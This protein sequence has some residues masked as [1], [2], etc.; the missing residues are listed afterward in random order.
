MTR[1][2]PRALFALLALLIATPTLLTACDQATPSNDADTLL[3]DARIARQGGDIDTAID[4]FEDALALDPT[5]AIVRVELS[6][7]YFER[8]DIDL[9]DLDRVALFLLEQQPGEAAPASPSAPNAVGAT[10]TYATDPTAT[11][12]DPRAMDGYPELVADRATVQQVLALLSFIIPDELRALSLCSGI[13]DGEL[14]YEHESAL[15]SMRAFGLSDAQIASALAIN[16]VARLLNAY[17][18]LAEDIAPQTQWYRLADGDIGVCADD[19]D[20]IRAQSE[21]AINDLGEV[22]TSLDLRGRALGGGSTQTRDIL[23]HA[24]EAYEAIAD[25]LGPYCSTP[26]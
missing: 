2:S 19:L 24:I 6:S 7:A 15:A 18:F 1:I 5:S 26:Q 4:L 23:D 9:F 14:I 20:A 11:A 22:L 21:D 13:A 16:A 10:C 25:H 12:F 8:A 3:T 17:F